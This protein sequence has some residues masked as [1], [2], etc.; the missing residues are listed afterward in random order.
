M[1]YVKNGTACTRCDSLTKGYCIAP[2]RNV[3]DIRIIESHWYILIYINI[4]IYYIRIYLRV[5]IQNQLCIS[6]EGLHFEHSIPDLIH[7]SAIR[8]TSASL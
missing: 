6:S 5:V 2:E 8:R 3:K 7:P 1:C 4:Y